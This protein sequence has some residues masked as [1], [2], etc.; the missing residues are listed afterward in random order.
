MSADYGDEQTG[1]CAFRSRKEIR[2]MPSIYHAG[3]TILLVLVPLNAVMTYVLVWHKRI[4]YDIFH[5]INYPLGHTQ[6]PIADA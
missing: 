2:P 6:H 5:R 4:G 3:T 1:L